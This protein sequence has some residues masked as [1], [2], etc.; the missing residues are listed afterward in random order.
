MPPRNIQTA[1]HLTF[2][3]QPANYKYWSRRRQNPVVSPTPSCDSPPNTVG[4]WP[5]RWCRGSRSER[6]TKNGRSSSWHK[7]T[8]QPTKQPSEQATEQASEHTQE[9]TAERRRKESRQT[10]QSKIMERKNQRKIVDKI[11]IKKTKSQD[12]IN[13]FVTKAWKPTKQRSHETSEKTTEI[14]R[15][16]NESKSRNEPIEIKERTNQ[17]QGTNESKS[18]KEGTNEFVEQTSNRGRAT[19]EQTNGATK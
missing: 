6:G 5:R 19:N 8:R 17:N 3:S 11:R 7:T 15:R 16:T 9:R 18:R 1:K 4:S 12:D 13:D 10:K 2:N 14:L